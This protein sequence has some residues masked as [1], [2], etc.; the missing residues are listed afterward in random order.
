[1]KACSK[2]KRNHI[3]YIYITKILIILW[4]AY[5]AFNIMEIEIHRI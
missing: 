3:N 5:E 1:M 4:A 2:Y